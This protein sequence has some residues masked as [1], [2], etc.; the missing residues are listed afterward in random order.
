MDITDSLHIADGVDLD[1]EEGIDR[2]GGEKDIYFDVLRS[3]ARAT[4]PLLET[5]GGVNEAGLAD[6]AIVVHGIK[7]SSLGIFADKVARMAE[8]LEKAAKAGDFDYVSKHNAA[9]IE[10]T[11]KL[12]EG[13]ETILAQDRAGEPKARKDK[14]DPDLLGKLRD[15]CILHAIGDVDSI[16]AELDSYE[17]ESGGELVDWLLDNAIMMN[18]DEIKERLSI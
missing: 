4:P 10:A 12:V 14:P 17:Y 18:Y 11:R 6:Y 15:A 7:G 3:Y 5:A 13:I 2:F 16:V 9:F 8:A 1:V